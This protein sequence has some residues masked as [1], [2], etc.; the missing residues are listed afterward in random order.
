MLFFFIKN[1]LFFLAFFIYLVKI[2][3]SRAVIYLDFNWTGDIVNWNGN[4][5]ET[6]IKRERGKNEP[7]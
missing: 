7:F 3:G 2:H 6:G 4:G 5:K 1:C